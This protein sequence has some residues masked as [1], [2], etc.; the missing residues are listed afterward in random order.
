MNWD[1]D[2][3]EEWLESARQ[4]EEDANMLRK[5]EKADEARVKELT[6]QGE[7]L[8][9]EVKR[10]RHLLE[11]EVTNTR[12]HELGLDKVAELFRE[13]HEERITLIGQW[14]STVKQMQLEDERI[15]RIAEEFQRIVF[16]FFC[17]L[18]IHCCVCDVHDYR[19]SV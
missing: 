19:C 11:N 15:D 18:L 9:V 8:A 14:E 4:Q 16:V 13:A 17:S 6:L 7:K 10:Q 2:Q 1:K 12:E 5:Y 3:L